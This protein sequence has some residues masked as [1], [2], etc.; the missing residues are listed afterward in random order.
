MGCQKITGTIEAIG[1]STYNEVTRTY[2]YIRIIKDDGELIYLRDFTVAGDI[3]SYIDID[4]QGDF[5]VAQDSAK[6]F[7]KDAS[8]HIMFG[9]RMKSG[10]KVFDTTALEV[11]A[12]GMKY[13]AFKIGGLGLFLTLILIGI[14]VVAF[15]VYMRLNAKQWQELKDGARQFFDSV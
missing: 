4:L 1:Q 8:H 2:S 7:G 14:P 10:R 6:L 5:Y 13:L 3:D 9:L 12:E 11:Q 15:A